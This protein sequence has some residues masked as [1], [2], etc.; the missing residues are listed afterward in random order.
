MYIPSFLKKKRNLGVIIGLILLLVY[1]NPPFIISTVDFM[2]NFIVNVF[3]LSLM[4]F[5]GIIGY[6]T[7]RGGRR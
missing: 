7:V 1:I 4:T 5:M 6:Y 2:M 3:L